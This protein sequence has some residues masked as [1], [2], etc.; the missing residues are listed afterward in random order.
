MTTRRAPGPRGPEALEVGD[1][2]VDL[3]RREHALERRQ[4]VE[5]ADRVS[6]DE[7]LR[8]RATAGARDEIGARRGVT[9]HVD[10]VVRDAARREE[11]LRA[12]AERAVRRAIHLDARHRLEA[13][14]RAAASQPALTARRRADTV[15]RWPTRASPRRSRTWST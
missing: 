13:R 12:Q 9:A 11:A 3:R 6:V 5:A 8:H 10:L 4:L 14:P 15:A 2:L 7:D 1:D